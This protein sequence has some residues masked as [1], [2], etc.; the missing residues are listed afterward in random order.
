MKP[1]PFPESNSVFGPP[2]GM[3]ESQ[4]FAVPAHLRQVSGGSCDGSLQVIVA[5][6]PS[7]LDLER[8]QKGSLIYLSVLG[9]LPPHFLSTSFTETQIA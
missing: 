1:V 5:W 4:V 7:D 8:L 6:K 2:K 3:E 9:G